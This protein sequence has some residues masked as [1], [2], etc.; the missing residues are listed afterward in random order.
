MDCW[1]FGMYVGWLGRWIV[2]LIYRWM[3]GWLLD[4]WVFGC[5][6][7]CDVGGLVG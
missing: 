5:M 6:V 2:G 3:D 1:L 7:G 4:G